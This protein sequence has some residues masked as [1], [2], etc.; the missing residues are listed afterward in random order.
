MAKALPFDTIYL[1]ASGGLDVSECFVPSLA[2]NAF[3]PDYEVYFEAVSFG[4]VKLF[5]VAGFEA[6]VDSVSFGWQDILVLEETPFDI[7]TVISG[8]VTGTRQGQ[9]SHVNI[10]SAARGTPNC[11]VRDPL[12]TLAEWEG[13]L[14]RLACTATGLEIARR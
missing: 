7:L 4:R 5:D 6:A 2:I 12:T 1:S 9:L 11:F 8:V 3:S 14:V 10:R 13:K